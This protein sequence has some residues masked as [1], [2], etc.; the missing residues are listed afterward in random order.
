[1]KVK[2]LLNSL[3]NEATS[4]MSP[5]SDEVIIG[6]EEQEIKKIA[7]CFKLTAKIIDE[8]KAYGAD[9]IIT[10]EGLWG[11]GKPISELKGTDLK[12]YNHLKESGMT[13]FRFHDHAHNRA[14]DFIHVGFTQ[15]LGLE[16]E[17][18][19]IKESFAIRSYQL[20]KP[21]TVQEIANLI[22]EKI[23]INTIRLI[24]DKNKIVKKLGL[25]LGWVDLF[26]NDYID[27]NSVDLIISGEVGSELYTQEYIKD[28]IYYGGNNCLMLL[29]YYGAE[30]TGMQYFANVLKE[31]GFEVKYFDSL[32]TYEDL[33]YNK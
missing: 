14:N 7:V 16:V 11:S 28:S 15:A 26:L 9:T 17:K 29:G 6:N 20:K 4:V 12:K 33:I 27:D 25:G 21:M 18:E 5:T 30:I 23:G 22:N 13:V 32:K 19:Y 10:H 24:G 1:M 3:I 2:E 8:A 31:R